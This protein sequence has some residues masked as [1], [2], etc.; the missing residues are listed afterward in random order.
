MQQH[1]RELRE[2]GER[3]ARRFGGRARNGQE[4]LLA[5]GVVEPAQL[6]RAAVGR[7]RPGVAEL[8]GTRAG[9]PVVEEEPEQTAAVDLQAVRRAEHEVRAFA[10]EAD[11]AH[12]G[13]EI[14]LRDR[15]HRA[16]VR[17]ILRERRLVLPQVRLGPRPQ[18]HSG[19]RLRRR[20]RRASQDGCDGQQ[21]EASGG[22]ER[23][24]RRLGGVYRAWR[25]SGR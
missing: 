5:M 1:P 3:L 16:V 17:E 4:D 11:L 24:G 19:E 15:E 23:H 18:L 22:G 7:E 6:E 25:P 8:G 13:V 2:L 12:E 20:V 14:R 9:P 10:V 21:G